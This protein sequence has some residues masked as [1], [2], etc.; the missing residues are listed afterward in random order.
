MKLN[1]SGHRFPKEVILQCVQ[2]WG[3]Y[4]LSSRNLEEMMKDRGV[5]VDHSSIDRWVKKFSS[6]I[7]ALVSKIKKNTG[8][9]WKLDET[10]VKVGGKWKYLY[11][12][13]DSEGQTIDFLLTAKRDAKAAKRFLSRAVKRNS[14]PNKIN[15]DKSGSNKKAIEEFNDEHGIEIEITQNKYRNNIIEQDHRH[16]KKLIK[17]RQHFRSFHSAQ[18]KIKGIES[19][20]MIRKGQVEGFSSVG[21]FFHALATAA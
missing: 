7:D 19:I 5:N 1:F 16:P 12:A 17:C 4:P 11:R 21:E 20:N 10:Y 9:S 8:N 15:I 6:M 14:I 13:V 3:R 2:W 18:Q